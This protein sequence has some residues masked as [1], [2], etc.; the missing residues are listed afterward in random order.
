M[1]DPFGTTDPLD[2]LFE[3]LPNEYDLRSV[4]RPLGSAPDALWHVWLA[5]SNYFGREIANNVAALIVGKLRATDHATE[6][7][8]SELSRRRE[9]LIENMRR[10]GERDF[11]LF[12]FE[13]S[14]FNKTAPTWSMDRA[15]A[16]R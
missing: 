14:G 15:R 1:L 12:E 4:R 13:R 6:E 2:A 16:L 11:P 9:S 7:M 5:A 3:K 10:N 8:E